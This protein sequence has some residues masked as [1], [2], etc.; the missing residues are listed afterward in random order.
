[1]VN[2]ILDPILI[3]G[4]G[5]PAMGIRG[6]AIATVIGQWVSAVFGLLLNWLQ[7]KELHFRKEYII[8]R[9]H[10]AAM[11][12]KVGAPTILTQACGSIMMALMNRV[13]FI[14]A[15][16]AIAFFGVYFKLQ[17]FLFMPMNGL[18][19]GTLPIVSYNYGAKKHARIQQACKTALAVG[20]GIGLFGT[21]LFEIAPA[22][23]LNLFNASAEMRSIG[24]PALRIISLTFA[25]SA[26]TLLC[27]YFLSA[28]G[29]GL[30]HM[31]ATALRQVILL[32][33]LVTLFAVLGGTQTMWFAFWIAELCAFAFALSQF[34]R[35]WKKIQQ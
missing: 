23:L 27:G 15:P 30:V 12:Y 13:L 4:I 6:A 2:L 20:I 7:N 5:V 35:Q 33:P 31:T 14:F 3:F 16:S 8:P 21:A 9:K 19:Q 10:I 17:N 25:F 18:G 28:M 24:V 29:N 11:I 1:L 34:R 32:I 22:G 26:V